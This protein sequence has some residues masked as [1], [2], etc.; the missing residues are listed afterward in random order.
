MSWAIDYV[1]KPWANGAAGPLAFD[2]WGLVRAVYAERFGIVLPAVDC[3][4]HAPL[5]VRHAFAAGRQGEDWLPVADR[6]EG[7]V[8]L[9]GQARRPH[10]VGVWVAGGVLHAVE[11]S[12]VVHQTP[13]R[14]AVHGW[15]LL[16]A[17]RHRSA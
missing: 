14:L 15:R 9:M 7:D 16:G 5:A 6:R 8:V 1:G 12:G 4:A 2:C 17:Y 13:P 11:G 10:H 3:D